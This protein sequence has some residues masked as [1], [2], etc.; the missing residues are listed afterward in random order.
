MPPAFRVLVL[1]ARAALLCLLRRVPVPMGLSLLDHV[2]HPAQVAI[3]IG[4]RYRV[5]ARRGEDLAKTLQLGLEYAPAPPFDSG[6]PETAPAAI[7]EAYKA[8]M[9]PFMPRREAEAREAAA[10]L[11]RT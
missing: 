1:V 6:S 8:R 2:H 5:F 11:G 7:L 4:T 3:L 9:A 10:R